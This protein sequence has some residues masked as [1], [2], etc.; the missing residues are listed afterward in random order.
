MIEISKSDRRLVQRTLNET[1]KINLK[2]DGV[3]GPKTSEAVRALKLKFNLGA[4]DD[5]D[6]KTW[7]FMDVYISKRFVRESDIVSAA[8]AIGV[9]P[10]MVFAIYQVE[11]LGTGSLPDGRPLILFERHKFYQYVSARLGRNTAEEWKAKY[12][13]ICHPTWSQA[14]YKGY[15][16]EWDRMQTARLLDGTCALMS[17]SWG[18]FQIMGFNFALADYKDVQSFTNAMFVTEQNHLNAL[19]AFIKNQ[20]PFYEALKARNYNRVAEL[21]N[22]AAYA[23]HG[24]HTR[25]RNADEANLSFNK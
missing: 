5:I 10:S 4:G 16:G 23:K 14:A 13:N 1:L 24:Y 12:P 17:A 25:L 9:M 3:F 8:R 19:L 7:R 21:Y 20:R 22:G 15:E 6:E 11:G 2:A 18:M